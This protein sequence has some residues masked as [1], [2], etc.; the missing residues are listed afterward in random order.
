[1]PTPIPPD[2]AD[3]DPSSPTSYFMLEARRQNRETL[4]G[5]PPP[6]LPKS[7]PWSSDPCGPEPTINREEDG[8]TF[9]TPIDQA[10]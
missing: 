5:E 9:G 8:D 10:P 1:M 6:K 2:I 4:G 3:D 7:S